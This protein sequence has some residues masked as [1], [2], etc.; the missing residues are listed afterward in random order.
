M[1]AS[2]Y[3]SALALDPDDYIA[4][5]NLA[6][7]L[8]YTRQWA[9]RE[10]LAVRAL[11]V[12]GLWQAYANAIQAQLLQGRVTEA[13]A[14]LDRYAEAHPGRAATEWQVM[15]AIARREY[16]MVEALLREQVSNTDLPPWPRGNT[17]HKLGDLL[18][19]RG[20]VAEAERWYRDWMR[21]EHGSVLDFHAVYHAA[22]LEAEYG[23]PSEAMRLLASY[24]IDSLPPVERP[25]LLLA[26]FH[27]SAGLLDRARALVAEFEEQVEPGVRRVPEFRHASLQ[28][29]GEIALSEGRFD[30]A[31]TDFRMANELS[32]D[33]VTCGLARLAYSLERSGQEDSALAV[34][35]RLVAPPIWRLDGWNI[36][37]FG[38]QT[39]RGLP[40]SYRR[41]GE[42]YE[43]RNDISNA[44]K[45]YNEFV[46]LW[47]DADP[48]LQPQVEDVRRRI[49]S[50]VGDR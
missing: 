38:I 16:D 11:E 8:R 39:L 25:Y 6:S 48:E 15:V 5:T 44:I 17:M 26:E 35:E 37:Q 36:R 13:Q 24:S 3:R 12:R 7:H 28:V 43:A 30:D 19:L 29:S 4:L 33:C 42:L 9:E 14:T 45:Y 46:E 1:V 40:E 21:V 41:L 18:R 49:A 20:Q 34:Y 32:G 31:A 10:S 47:T 50:L 2:A 23:S 27:A 22:S